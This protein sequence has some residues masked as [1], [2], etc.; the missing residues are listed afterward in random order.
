M[1]THWVKIG[2]QWRLR[3]GSAD[4]YETGYGITRT[5]ATWGVWYENVALRSLESLEA[6]KDFAEERF[7]DVDREEI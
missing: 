5:N 4:G 3:A 2:K 1:R 6:A 7:E